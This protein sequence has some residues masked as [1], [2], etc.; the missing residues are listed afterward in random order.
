MLNEGKKTRGRGWPWT[1]GRGQGLIIHYRDEPDD[2]GGQ[3]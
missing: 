2:R 1:Q 3:E